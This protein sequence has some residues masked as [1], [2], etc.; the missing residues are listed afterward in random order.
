MWKKFFFRK[1]PPLPA[2]IGK[3]EVFVR[4]C[5]SSKISQHKKRF[6]SFSLKQCYLNLLET[7]D[8]DRAKLTFFLDGKKE[9]HF[10][11]EEKQHKVIE[12]EAG[13][14]AV[15]FLKLLDYVEGLQLSPDII[16]YFL[17]DDYLHRPGWTSVL[18]EAFEIPGVDYATLYD[19]RDKY[20]F[21]EYKDLTS[22]LFATRSCHWRTVPS[23]TQT[24]AVRVQT[25]MEHL[26]IHKKF[27]E[28]R[29]IS[30]DHAKFCQLQKRGAILVSSIPGYSTHGEPEYASPCYDWSQHFF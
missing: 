29:K 9:D 1:E 30:A 17:E 15:S 20:F 24:F 8:F 18:L 7:I 5:I 22:R 28:K 3:M 2:P 27:S 19:H 13:S 4:H 6:P 25:L 10:L 23:T 16:V 12:V 14:E 21:P 26:S 11:R